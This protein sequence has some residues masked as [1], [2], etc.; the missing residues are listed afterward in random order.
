MRKGKS[1]AKKHSKIVNDFDKTKEKHL[2]KLATQMLET[3][4]K[5]N[6]LKNKLMKGN[7]LSKF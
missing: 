3:E 2:E 5:M 1:Y 7:F 4:K 6:K